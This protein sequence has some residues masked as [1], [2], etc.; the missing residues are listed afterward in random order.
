MW[1]SWRLGSLFRIPIEINLSFL[2][3]LGLVFVAFGGLTGVLIVGI[4]FASVLLHELGHALV[5][6]HLGVHTASIELGFLGGAAKMVN[7]PRTPNH[8]IAIAVAGPAVSLMLGGVGLGL[9]F[10]VGSPLLFTIGWI[11][12]VL[13]AFNMI[14]ALPMDGGRVLRAVLA[15]RTSFVR[16]TDI[17]VTVSRVVAVAFAIVGVMGMYQLLIIAPFL[18]LMGTR[19]RMMARMM[20]DG[21]Y[22]SFDHGARDPW[23]RPSNPWGDAHRDSFDRGGRRY[24]IVRRNGAIQVIEVRE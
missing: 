15:R 20:P 22:D 14:P 21:P 16:A 11:N 3:L 10:A 13:A 18:W 1:K 12:L 7:L 5:G 6:R 2:I 17:A 24:T 4:A 8:E 19:E 23:H 9:G